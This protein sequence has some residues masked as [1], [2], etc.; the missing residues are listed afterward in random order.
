[1]RRLDPEAEAAGPAVPDD[2]F[3][4]LD[5]EPAGGA[6]APSAPPEAP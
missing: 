4:E 1:V 2:E 6:E 3:Y 5:D